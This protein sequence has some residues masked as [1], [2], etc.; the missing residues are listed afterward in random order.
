[1]IFSNFPKLV[2]YMWSFPWR[3]FFW[4][5]SK[6]GHILTAFCCDTCTASCI[7]LSDAWL[8]SWPC[9]VPGGFWKVDIESHGSDSKGISYEEFPGKRRFLHG[10]CL[11][12]GFLG[13]D[14]DFQKRES[15]LP[16]GP[17]YISFHVTVAFRVCPT[18]QRNRGIVM[19]H[20]TTATH[21][22]LLPCCFSQV[23][24]L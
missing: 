2:G 18:Q 21:L 12:H 7:S 17:W 20:S 3:V 1:M 9:W 5:L 4:W 24:H 14:D 15:P 22:H 6:T 19:E 16:V 23:N 11:F 10:I 13:K 8:S